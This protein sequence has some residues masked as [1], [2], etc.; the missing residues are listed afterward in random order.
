M[1]G[2]QET[3]LVVKYYDEAFG[4][5]SPAE[6]NWYI[7][8]VERFGAP[9]LDLACG[10]G[11]L[12][13]KMAERGWDVTGIDPSEGMLSRFQE[14]MSGASKALTSKVRIEKQY[15]HQFEINQSFKTIICCDA[16]FHN[17][18]VEAEIAC[19]E[20]VHAHLAPDGR[21]V[22]NLPNPTCSFI[23]HAE[24][25][26]GS[27][28]KERARI[29]LKDGS[30]LLIEHAQAGDRLKQTIET[31]H[32]VSRYAKSGELLE[33]KESKWKSRYLF[34]YEAVHLLHRCGFE[35]EQVSSDYEDNPVTTAGQLIFRAKKR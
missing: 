28:F 16:F 20:R 35:V 8:Q 15:M 4:V 30:M 31:T 17:E 3:D 23:E 18:T 9:V 11:R 29:A 24:Q 21:F 7:M 34:Q 32:R 22:F 6:I 25:S 12:A 2:S 19:L 26:Q 10:T 1:Y 27:V 14:K 13:L 33:K 5:G